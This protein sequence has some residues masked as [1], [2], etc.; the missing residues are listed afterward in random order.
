VVRKTRTV[1]AR[2]HLADIALFLLGGERKAL[3]R[4][5]GRRI[6]PAHIHADAP[7]RVLPPDEGTARAVVSRTFRLS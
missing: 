7:W 2:T 4:E 3:R 1:N 6:A 5:A